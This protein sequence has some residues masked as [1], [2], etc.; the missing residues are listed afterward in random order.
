[1]PWALLGRRRLIKEVNPLALEYWIARFSPLIVFIVRHP[2]AIAA[3]YVELGWLE[4]ADVRDTSN[5]E[6]LTPF[7]VFG[8]RVG[9]I[10][11]HAFGVLSNYAGKYIVVRYESLVVHEASEL[12]KI[13]S[14]AMLPLTP[15]DLVSD[16]ESGT[17]KP[18][19]LMQSPFSLNRRSADQNDKW[20]RRL[21]PAQI[22]EV[23]SGYFRHRCPFYVGDDE[24]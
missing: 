12:A 4:N 3:S 18:R 15:A 5:V 7:E 11:H 9:E 20:R 23:R 17:S 19:S 8:L 2:A 21:S 14:F 1:L 16:L 24:W 13:S 22:S 10:Y 6:G